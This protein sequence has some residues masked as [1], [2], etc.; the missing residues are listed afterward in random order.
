MA[1]ATCVD[2]LAVAGG[3]YTSRYGAYFARVR[4]ASSPTRYRHGRPLDTPIT[5]VYGGV[6][7]EVA[8][9]RS[10]AYDKIKHTKSD[11]TIPLPTC[12]STRTKIKKVGDTVC[13]QVIGGRQQQLVSGPA[14]CAEIH[15]SSVT[16]WI[17]RVNAGKQSCLSWTGVFIKC[18]S[19][20]V[21]A[22]RRPPRRRR[23][24]PKT[25]PSPTP[26]RDPPR[27][28]RRP[29]HRHWVVMPRRDR[30]PLL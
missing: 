21:R 3:P 9:S 12:T 4:P 15:D 19:P 25:T 6:V 27:G 22:H 8:N 17:G 30:G 24:A 18:P 20:C 26:G 23:K 10:G 5:A 16:P 13:G 2:L 29:R 11:G 28:D 14:T 7:E 1:T